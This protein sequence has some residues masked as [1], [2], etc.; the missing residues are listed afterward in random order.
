[1][2]EN[3]VE[4]AGSSTHKNLQDQSALSLQGTFV[5]SVGYAMYP[6]GTSHTR[7]MRIQP[8]PPG[9]GTRIIATPAS[10]PH[11]ASCSGT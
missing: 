5:S 2:M 4:V 9:H 6:D 10:I 11:S 8:L 3:S 1:M 7:K